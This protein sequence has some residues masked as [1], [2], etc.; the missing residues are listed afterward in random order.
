M[1]RKVQTE[2]A[3]T[4]LPSGLD[5]RLPHKLSQTFDL[6]EFVKTFKVTEA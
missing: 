5:D 6:A 1:P 4:Y 3:F 2:K